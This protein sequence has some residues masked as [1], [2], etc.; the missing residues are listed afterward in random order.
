[1]VA[2]VGLRRHL[3]DRWA[4]T[5]VQPGKHHLGVIFRNCKKPVPYLEVS[6]GGRLGKTGGEFEIACLHCGYLGTNPTSELR[7]M[8]VHRKQ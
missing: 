8:E 2:A 7:T 3:R 1:M 6:P 4:M 5:K